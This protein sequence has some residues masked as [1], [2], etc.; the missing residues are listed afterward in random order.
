MIAVIEPF[1]LVITSE[2]A[3][4]R[5]WP[6]RFELLEVTLFQAGFVAGLIAAAGMVSILYALYAPNPGRPN[7]SNQVLMTLLKPR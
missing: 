1:E 3:E 4:E 7:S 5:G 2:I 6:R